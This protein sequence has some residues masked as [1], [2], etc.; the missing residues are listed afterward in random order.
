MNVTASQRCI[1]LVILAII[2][3]LALLKGVM[4][5]AEV[6]ELTSTKIQPFSDQ[7]TKSKSK[8]KPKPKLNPN[9]S[10]TDVKVNKVVLI[11]SASAEE[12]AKNLKGIGVA[13][14][15]RIV[16]RRQQQGPYQDFDQLKAVSGVGVAKIEANRD[17][18][19]FD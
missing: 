2:F 8:S 12:I 3:I 15:Q 16:L 17:R 10:A 4:Q 9:K 13:I 11:N 6:D 1:L 19:S 18:I 7:V 14:A 5:T